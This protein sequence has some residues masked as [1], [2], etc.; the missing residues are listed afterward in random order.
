MLDVSKEVREE[1]FHETWETGGF[2][3]SLSNY[4]DVVLNP[5]ANEVVYQYWR[6]RVCERLKDPEKQNIMAPEKMPYYYGTKRSPLE[7]DYYEILVRISTNRAC[8][9]CLGDLLTLLPT[10]A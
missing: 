9:G 7:Q 10:A 1:H 2:N 6:K 5:K 3:F 8:R 4:N